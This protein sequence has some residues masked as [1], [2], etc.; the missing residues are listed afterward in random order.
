MRVR[1]GSGANGVTVINCGNN[2]H[3]S[4][5]CL[6]ALTRVVFL[7]PRI[8]LV[9]GVFSLFCYATLPQSFARTIS[10]CARRT[11]TSTRRFASRRASRCLNPARRAAEPQRPT[12]LWRILLPLATVATFGGC[13][14]Q[15][16]PKTN[17]TSTNASGA[18]PTASARGRRRIHLLGVLQI[19]RVCSGMTLRGRCFQTR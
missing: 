5:R 17:P 4:A 8:A 18:T 3:S 12:Y 9:L 10:R 1:T 19:T 14:T 7:W 13:I 6:K 15:M 11:T 2:D 16:P